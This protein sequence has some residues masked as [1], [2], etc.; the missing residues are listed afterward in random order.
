MWAE[1]SDALADVGSQLI[2]LFLFITS[3]TKCKDLDILTGGSR[4]ANAEK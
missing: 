2:D 1:N 4:I 3:K